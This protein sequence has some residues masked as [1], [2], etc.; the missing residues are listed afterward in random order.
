MHSTVYREIMKKLL[1]AVVLV[2]TISYTL[3]VTNPD[4]NNFTRWA[5]ERAVRKASTALEK[6][7]TNLF[8]N[9]VI[10]ASTDRIDYR[11]FSIYKITMLDGSN[12]EILGMIGLFFPYK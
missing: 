10:E 11:F 12:H 7:L 3:F 5:K 8:G 9:M 2:A 4:K 6:G 1:I